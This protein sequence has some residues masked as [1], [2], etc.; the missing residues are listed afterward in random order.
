MNEIQQT[1]PKHQTQSNLT[2]LKILFVLTLPFNN[3]SLLPAK[4]T[5]VIKTAVTVPIF[6]ETPI[7]LDLSR[8]T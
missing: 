8:E 5:G 4:I 1:P 7:Y 3:L 2:L 6:P